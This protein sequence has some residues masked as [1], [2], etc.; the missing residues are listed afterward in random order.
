MTAKEYLQQVK[1]MDTTVKN[2]MVELY[3]LRCLATSITA[4]PDREAVQTSGISDKVGN[5]GA[6][7]VDLQ[8]EI[9]GQIDEY[10]QIKQECIDIIER[11]RPLNDLQY[12]ILHKKY[13]GN[14]TLRE[15]AEEEC[16]SYDYIRE[17]HG[18]AL[19][20]VA[21]IMQNSKVPTQTHIQS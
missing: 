12:N 11:V 14:Q 10:I 17:S 5:I 16:Y 4:P 3:Q 20:K 18:E 8:N 1:E 2:K 7:I 19:K 6:K 9:M 21:K 13:V 15:I